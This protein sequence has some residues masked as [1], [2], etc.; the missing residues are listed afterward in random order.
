MTM[1]EIAEIA[2]VSV[3]TVSKLLN[4]KPNRISAET[5]ERVLKVV[6]EYHYT[7]NSIA[8]GLKI[9]RTNTLGFVLPDIRNPYFSEIGKGIQDELA[10]HNYGVLFCNTD[11]DMKKEESAL[12]MLDTKMVDGVIMTQSRSAEYLKNSNLGHI[13]MVFV[14]RVPSMFEGIGTVHINEKKEFYKSTSYL[15]EH[16]CKRI[17]YISAKPLLS[18]ERLAGYEEALAKYQIPFDS[19]LIYLGEYDVETGNKGIE[20]IFSD[21]ANVDGVVCGNDLIAIGVLNWFNENNIKVPSEVKVIGF[22]DIYISSYLNPKL[23]TIAQPA[24]QMGAQAVKMLLNHINNEA[25]LEK[26]ELEC[27]LVI[28]DTV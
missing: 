8:K 25:P 4:N 21:C 16:D 12:Y 24:Y 28:R 6:Q 19:D 20:N 26:V 18:N 11:N 1:K 9:K 14:D 13:P 22:D 27:T 7:P 17:A 2:G 5:R 15:L 10:K 3:A 23:T